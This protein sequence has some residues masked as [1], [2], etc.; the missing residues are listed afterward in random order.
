[1]RIAG[2]T[3]EGGTQAFDTATSASVGNIY[4]STDNT[5]T[6]ITNI[7]ATLV[8]DTVWA[9]NTADYGTK[10]DTAKAALYEAARQSI[11]VLVDVRGGAGG[12]VQ[13]PGADMRSLRPDLSADFDPTTV[14][15]A[16][17]GGTL[18]VDTD[19]GQGFTAPLDDGESTTVNITGGGQSA[20]LVISKSGGLYAIADT[21]VSADDLLE[22]DG[23]GGKQ[24]KTGAVGFSALGDSFV[25]KSFLLCYGTT[26]SGSGGL[27]SGDPFIRTMLK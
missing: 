19:A 3:I 15:V 2:A 20:T 1:M 21:A 4:S 24:T 17:A 11:M 13:I 26:G 5:D 14:L 16:E 25:Y 6:K 12:A 27:A 23:S 7:L 22:A 8:G 10:A 18:V 9:S